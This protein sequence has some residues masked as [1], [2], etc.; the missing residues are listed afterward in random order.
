METRTTNVFVTSANRETIKQIELLE[1]LWWNEWEAACVFQD[2]ARQ[3]D[4]ME[5]ITLLGELKEKF[6]ENI[7]GR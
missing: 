3:L 7:I 6:K 4:A 2:P 1:V 5:K